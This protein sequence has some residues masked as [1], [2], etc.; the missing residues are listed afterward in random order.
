MHA[1]ELPS[2]SVPACS[3]IYN[4]VD[5]SMDKQNKDIASA[6]AGIRLTPS[7]PTRIYFPYLILLAVT[8]FPDNCCILILNALL[9]LDCTIAALVFVQSAD[10]SRSL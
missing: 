10:F 4:V 8:S 1:P 3:L 5:A 9:Y 6:Y 7:P 2:R